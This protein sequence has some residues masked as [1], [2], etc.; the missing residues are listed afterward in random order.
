MELAELVEN[1]YN[2]IDTGLLSISIYL[3]IVSGYLIVAYTV[4]SKLSKS[5]VH[6]VSFLFVSFAVILTLSTLASLRSGMMM[7]S[8]T[9]GQ[10]DVPWLT[11]ALDV[12]VYGIALLEV[13]GI[14]L[15]LK[16]VY[17]E[18]QNAT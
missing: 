18:R 16:F 7:F 9:S 3:T 4:G 14:I 6:T 10:D 12:G 1:G 5:Q 11:I 13:A 15:S 17:D 2:A 8:H